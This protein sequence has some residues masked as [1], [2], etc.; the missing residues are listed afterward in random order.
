MSVV[1]S[2]AAASTRARIPPRIVILC[3]GS[4]LAAI[5]VN[6]MRKHFALV[7]VLREEPESK[8]AILRRR[9]RLVGWTQAVGQAAFG[10]LAKVIGKRSAGRLAQIL[11]T[12]DLDPQPHCHAS[13]REVGS[14]NSQACREA[15]AEVAP[16]VV[17]VYGTR[18][19]KKATLDAVAAPFINY[20]AGFNPLYRGQHGAYW[21]LTVGDRD[22]AGLTIH[23]V[24]EGVDTGA[25]LYQSV[26]RFAPADN[27]STY[28]C[29]QMADAIPLMIQ[30]AEDALAGRLH[31]RRV[32]LPSKQ[33]FLP[34]LW[35]YCRTGLQ[36]G[37]W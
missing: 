11:E 23:L 20:H 35:G 2:D 14:V 8:W 26:T 7:T 28:Q 10:V 36:T 1:S 12:Y 33:W 18:I 32:A 9:G 5:F 6:A 22:H 29:R 37:V 13:W 17:L 15:L 4:P 16:D 3:T 27:I 30:A 24:D 25:V 34:T 21:A 31:V 19:I